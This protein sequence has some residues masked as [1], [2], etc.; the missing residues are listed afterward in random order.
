MLIGA[1]LC[2]IALIILGLVSLGCSD[3]DENVA[4]II[5]GIFHACCAVAATV[6]YCLY[7]STA[8]LACGGLF[9]AITGALIFVQC[10]CED[11]DDAVRLTA[12]LMSVVD[13]I[14]AVIGYAIIFDFLALGISC[15]VLFVLATINLGVTFYSYEWNEGLKFHIPNIIFAVATAAGVVTG[16]AVD[17][18][19]DKE[20]SVEAECAIYKYDYVNSVVSETQEKELYFND[21]YALQISL[22][23]SGLRTLGTESQEV[24]IDLKFPAKVLSYISEGAEFTK[25]DSYGKE[26]SYNIDLNAKTDEQFKSGYFIFK[27]SY[28]SLTIPIEPFGV[29]ITT[30]KTSSTAES[31]DDLLF[32]DYENEFRYAFNKR[33]YKFGNEE[34]MKDLSVA[35]DGYYR[36]FIPQGCKSLKVKFYDSEKTGVYYSETV[37]ASGEY[38]RLN[39]PDILE[40]NV[41]ANK[42]NELKQKKA[43]LVVEIT[44]VGNDEYEDTGFEFSYTVE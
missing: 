32:N 9:T 10:V 5:C 22:E 1:I 34:C 15:V 11:C 26:W 29:Q 25:Y 31:E 24:R 3:S 13:F 33:R 37:S 20:V 36:I 35:D 23:W 14:C 16:F 8:S 41:N 12:L 7:S 18:C 42:Y 27:Y 28:A 6:M 40:R 30:I 44:A 19:I 21:Y 38:Y 43:T 39:I 17:A 4:T 2:S